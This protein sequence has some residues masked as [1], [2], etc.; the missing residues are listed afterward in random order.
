MTLSDAQGKTLGGHVIGDMV[1]YT[2]AEVVIGECS[3]AVFRREPDPKT[4]YDELV[5]TQ[6]TN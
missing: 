3:E 5:V 6:K 2:T 4:G 1:V